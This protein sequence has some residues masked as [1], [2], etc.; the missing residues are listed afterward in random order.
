MGLIRFN[1][2]APAHNELAELCRLL[3]HPARL[4]IIELLLSAPQGLT[5]SDFVEALPL[6][7]STVSTHLKELRRIG[8]IGTEVDGRY[9]VCRL[10]VNRFNYYSKKLGLFFGPVRQKP[11]RSG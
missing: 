8:L 7:Q 10:D 3:G 1:E 11:S 4:A 2:F 9:A 6:T 5:V